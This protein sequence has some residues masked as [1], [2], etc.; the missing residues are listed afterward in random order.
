MHFVTFEIDQNVDFPGMSLGPFAKGLNAVCG[1][2][3]SGKT[4]LSEFARSAFAARSPSLAMGNDA[5]GNDASSRL[6][7]ESTPYRRASKIRRRL[8]GTILWQNENGQHQ[9]RVNDAHEMAFIDRTGQF[10]G[11]TPSASRYDGSYRYV[12]RH[13]SSALSDRIP[14][15]TPVTDDDLEAIYFSNLGMASTDR[16]WRAADR[17]GLLE[18]ATTTIDSDRERMLQ[19][20]HELEARLQSFN[21]PGR[22]RAWWRSERARLSHELDVL[23]RHPRATTSIYNHRDDNSADINLARQT[24]SR[25][26]Q[27][28]L[29]LQDSIRSA[30]TQPYT[31]PPQ[32]VLGQYT[33]QLHEIDSRL[34]RWRETLQEIR[35]Q[36][37]SIEQSAV[38]L[39]LDRQLDI[40]RGS[41]TTRRVSVENLESRL[42]A[43]ESAVAALADRFEEY[44][45]DY[46]KT[47]APTRHWS[48]TFD[49]IQSELRAV[50]QRL[51]QNEVSTTADRIDSQIQQLA[52]CEQ[53][54]LIAIEKL[55]DERGVWIQRVSKETNVPAEE[56]RQKFG[57]WFEG[58]SHE[59]LYDWL[60]SDAKS[61]TYDEASRYDS[62]PSPTGSTSQHKDLLAQVRRD[63]D[64]AHAHLRWL[65]EHAGTA[66]HVPMIVDPAV[67]N[68]LRDQISECD[69]VLAQWDS[70]LAVEARLVELRAEIANRPVEI[71]QVRQPIVHAASL[72]LQKI[73]GDGNVTLPQWALPT[74]GIYE[75]QNEPESGSSF[76][77][78][79]AFHETSETHSQSRLNQRHPD[80]FHRECVE[81][82]IRMAIADAARSRIGSLPMVLDDP[83]RFHTGEAIHGET[84][85][86]IIQTINRFSSDY[87]QVILLTGSDEVASRVQAHHGFVCHLNRHRIVERPQYR[88]VQYVAPMVTEPFL[89]SP[90]HDVNQQLN[91]AAYDYENQAWTDLQRPIRSSRP[92]P[93]VATG[94]ARAADQY[95]LN[96]GSPVEDI[97]SM[98]RPTAAYLRSRGIQR[99]GD[100]LRTDPHQLALTTRNIQYTD[101]GYQPSEAYFRLLQSEA[102]LMCRVRQLRGFDARILVGCGIRTPQD[103]GGV[104]PTELLHRAEAFLA[105]PRGKDI[106]RSGNSFELSRLTSWLASAKR[107][108]TASQRESEPNHDP[109]RNG[110]PVTSFNGRG[111]RSNGYRDSSNSYNEYDVHGYDY[112]R[113]SRDYS[114]RRS[115]ERNGQSP[116]APLDVPSYAGEPRSYER[117]A[118]TYDRAPRDLR[119]DR[120]LKRRV[121]RHD[122]D[123][124]F[125][126]RESRA[127]RGRIV[128]ISRPDRDKDR[129][130]IRRSHSNRPAEDPANEYGASGE[131]HV[132]RMDRT[133]GTN[134]N[135]SSSLRFY[136]ELDANVV[137]APS[138]G[139]R[140][141]EHLEA[142]GVYTVRD[143]LNSS[144]EI[145]AEQLNKRRVT[146]ETV[147]AWQHQARLVCQ[148]PNLR[149]HDAQLLVAAEIY[150]PSE[151]A[152]RAP[153]VLLDVI[154]EVALSKEGQRYLRGSSE[155]DLEEV[156]NWID[157][158]GQ[159]RSLAAA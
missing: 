147:V 57:N 138:I 62:N 117:P 84:L 116:N 106:L 99:V 9:C 132:V 23:L 148:I 155:P 4:T 103:L 139:P 71:H 151:L 15:A 40:T 87:Q 111:H 98:D 129:S 158:A 36:R 21:R 74:T 20:Q 28:E 54:L 18:Q 8:A 75:L 79:G 93:P 153:G 72:Y 130:T 85:D 34:N 108:G 88:D 80:A 154:L 76:T 83:F 69:T 5:I 49:S 43:A 6:G 16:L 39:R 145:I 86:R 156:T 125:A 41:E 52:R 25:L 140:M 143:L 17:L 13:A 137:D 58:T 104:P 142:F 94:Y 131:N 48:S 121:E 2:R 55:V 7:P 46:P 38:E 44:G 101:G 12:D 157:W 105:T 29:E 110:S 61:P 120:Q 31:A 64:A 102:S 42:R 144:P 60:I 114:N 150:E 37:Q 127:G 118:A 81:L 51:S 63:L 135:S 92:L 32:R 70:Y 35:Q 78:Y 24:V 96:Q 1:A 27:R 56:L 45:R 19:E 68:R 134:D 11:S 95:H 50:S 73:L 59:H 159:Y 107:G 113:T 30:Q 123:E 133:A 115:Y 97:P 122:A 53:E 26:Q 90:Y 3:S 10:L 77:R 146:S 22:N 149:G 67:E 14:T 136:L 33:S 124:S 152:A 100:F 47:W 65:I 128:R 66:E 91:A 82:A 119:N 126:E 109:G 89:T 141:A 112:D